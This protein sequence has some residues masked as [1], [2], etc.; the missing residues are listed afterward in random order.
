MATGSPGAHQG[1]HPRHR[2]TS[3]RRRSR[4]SYGKIDIVVANAAIQRSVAILEMEDADWRDVVDNN[5][6]GTAIRSERLD[7][8]SMFYLAKAT[9][10]HM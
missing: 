8:R 5:L 2:S 7:R 6:N 9:V 3:D 1:R 10:P 4:K